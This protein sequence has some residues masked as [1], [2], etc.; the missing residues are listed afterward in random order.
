MNQI[1]LAPCPHCRSRAHVVDIHNGFAIVCEDKNCLGQMRV[2][3]GSC[4]DKNVFLMKLVSDW[5][6][7]RPEIRAVTAAVECLTQ[8]RN[9]LYDANQKEYAYHGNCCIEALDEAI[10]RL[11]CFTSTNAVEQWI[12]S[13]T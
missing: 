2:H 7:R 9:E 11:K 4:D 13:H 5:N 8:Y 6:K 3:Y 10:N 1:A 12:D